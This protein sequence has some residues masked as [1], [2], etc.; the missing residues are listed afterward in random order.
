[1]DYL[2]SLWSYLKTEKVRF[3]I[4][5]YIRAAVVIASVMAMVRIIWD[6]FCMI[7]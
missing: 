2:Y 5:D 7:K 4:I 6:M 3:E 1:M